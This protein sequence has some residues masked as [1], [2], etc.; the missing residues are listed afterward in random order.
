MAIV[1]V[2]RRQTMNNRAH[3]NPHES[4]CLSLHLQTLGIQLPPQ[5]TAILSYGMNKGLVGPELICKH[6]GGNWGVPGL[7]TAHIQ[8][9]NQQAGTNVTSSKARCSSLMPRPAGPSW[10]HSIL[11]GRFWLRPHGGEGFVHSSNSVLHL[12]SNDLPAIVPSLLQCL[13]F[14]NI[15]P[16]ANPGFPLQN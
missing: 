14:I 1:K 8:W 10:S 9:K 4:L 11:P 2:Y 6:I 3:G 16:K 5:E 13:T 7:P 15:S 12:P